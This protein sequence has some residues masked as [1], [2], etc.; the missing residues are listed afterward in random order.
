[1][2]HV[3]TLERSKVAVK[4]DI[5]SQLTLQQLLPLLQGFARPFIGGIGGLATTGVFFGVGVGD[6]FTGFVVGAA[7]GVLVY[8]HRFLALL[9]LTMTLP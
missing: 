9:K 2:R 3:N 8:L 1:M 4:P 7:D 6:T 5:S